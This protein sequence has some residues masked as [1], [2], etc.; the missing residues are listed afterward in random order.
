MTKNWDEHVLEAEEVALGEGFQQ[1]RDRIL[2]EADAAIEETA[3]DIGAG[4][5]LLT[6]PLARLTRKVWAIDISPA[7]CALLRTRVAEQS[8]DNI[9]IAVASADR[10]PLEDETVELV[11]SNY[12]FHHLDDD[13][14]RRALAEVHRVL[15]PGGRL[16]FADMMFKVG[17]MKPRDRRVVLDKV[18]AMLRKGPA[19]VLRLAKNLYRF[20]TGRWERPARAH[21]WHAAL[22]E[23]GFAAVNVEEL[24]HEGGLATA[25]KP[26]VSLAPAATPS[27]TYTP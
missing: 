25:R 18:W 14:K 9:E 2:T 3:V 19:G 22:I 5:G 13:G 24:P 6:L 7:M 10:L 15:R 20:L 8:L 17:V 4:P 11:V 26:P 1:L 27:V 16:V 12:C 23:A 21:W